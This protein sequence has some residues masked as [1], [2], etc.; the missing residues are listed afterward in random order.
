L[1]CFGF[2]ASLVCMFDVPPRTRRVIA[3]AGVVG[4][5]LLVMGMLAS[6]ARG[7]PGPRR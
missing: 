3:V 7:S 1:V 2:T 5:G 4:L 6:P